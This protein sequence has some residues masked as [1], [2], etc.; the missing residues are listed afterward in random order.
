MVKLNLPQFVEDIQT[1]HPIA[2]ALIDRLSSA[3][4]KLS[5]DIEEGRVDIGET[6]RSILEYYKSIYSEPIEY[7][8]TNVDLYTVMKGYGSS[9]ISSE[10]REY[11]MLTLLQSPEV[12]S[13]LSDPVDVLLEILADKDNEN[14]RSPRKEDYT[15]VK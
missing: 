1:G 13:Y 8:Y 5:D 10:D 15:P 12:K 3:L 2:T 7:T 14:Y 6:Q 4:D 9:I 11:L